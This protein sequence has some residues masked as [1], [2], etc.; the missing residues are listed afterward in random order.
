MVG[1]TDRR[2][3]AR[4]ARHPDVARC[5]PRVRAGAQRM[6]SPEGRLRA[7]LAQRRR[8]SCTGR[9]PMGARRDARRRAIGARSGARA[10]H[11][12]AS[13]GR[14]APRSRDHQSE[15]AAART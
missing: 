1:A 14:H 10:H 4:C 2:V 13:M 5:R 11:Y 7:V 3:G 12:R 6:E 15:S 9:W 8:R